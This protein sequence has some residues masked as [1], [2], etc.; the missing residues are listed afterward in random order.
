MSIGII[1]YGV[2]NLGSVKR[3]IELAGGKTSFIKNPEDAED[4]KSLILPGVGNYTECYNKLKQNQWVEFFNKSFDS[5]RWSLLGICV[6]MQLLMELGYEGAS[7]EH[8]TP[9]LGLIKGVV[10]NLS[11][12]GCN[13][14]LPHVGWNSIDISK[15][16][17]SPCIF[18]GISN[19]TD[20][21]FV[22]SFGVIVDDISM[23]SATVNYGIDIVASV[24]NQNIFGTQFHP[25]KSSK[26]GLAL[27]KNFINIS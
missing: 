12:Q 14:R 22:H 24:A 2:G 18:D 19:K 15:K 16:G 5:N 6:G 21:Y 4:H 1:D 10:K 7:E 23:I 11:D 27:Y 25:E 3:A 8:P 13:N 17:Q 26:A 9:G 20:F